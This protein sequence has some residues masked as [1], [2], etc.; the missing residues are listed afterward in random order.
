MSCKYLLVFKL[1][2]LADLRAN[3]PCRR[4]SNQRCYVIH[5]TNEVVVEENTAFNTFGHCFFLEDGVEV[6]NIFRNNLGA[7]IKKSTRL[8]SE[9][10]GRIE[11]D[12]K[13][14]VFWI[15]NPANFL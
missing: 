11:T 10:S 15:S 7:G 3:S 14:S 2:L 8:L 1:S 12:D 4:D 9:K 13:P 6:N 5:G